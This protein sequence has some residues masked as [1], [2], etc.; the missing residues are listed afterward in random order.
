MVTMTNSLLFLLVCR[1]FFFFLCEME[2]L[3]SFIYRLFHQIIICI[4]DGHCLLITGVN[5]ID[6]YT[7]A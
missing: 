2:V 5:F 3:F 4:T 7:A 6:L 1:H